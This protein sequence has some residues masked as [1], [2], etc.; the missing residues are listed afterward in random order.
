MVHR[1]AAS[2]NAS[3]P[4]MVRLKGAGRVRGRPPPHQRRHGPL[5]P[6]KVGSWAL[7]RSRWVSERG[8]WGAGRVED[9]TLGQPQRGE[10]SLLKR[11]VL[12]QA[13]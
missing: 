8:A 7:E 10:C 1:G 13:Q 5:R 9:S 12:T 2:T 11:H 4:T 6:P 3:A